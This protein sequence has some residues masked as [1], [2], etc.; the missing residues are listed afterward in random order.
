M[1]VNGFLHSFL[2][3]QESNRH[4]HYTQ[5]DKLLKFCSKNKDSDSKMVASF[6]YLITIQLKVN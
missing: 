3:V 5:L 6:Q 2:Q 4:V 1:E